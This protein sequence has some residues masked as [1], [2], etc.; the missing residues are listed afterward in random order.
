MPYQLDAMDR[1]MH[2]PDIFNYVTTFV[3]NKD[4]YHMIYMNKCT[5]SMYIENYT[6][7]RCISV[8]EY[9]KYYKYAYKYFVKY[10]HEYADK[11]VNELNKR[12]Q[13]FRIGNIQE[14]DICMHAT[15]IIF[16]YYFNHPIDK[17]I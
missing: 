10:S 14:I 6:H 9:Y 17:V 2:I 8:I 5:L 3:S 16:E 11:Y 7:N 12:F 13:K 1:M 15:H 4:K